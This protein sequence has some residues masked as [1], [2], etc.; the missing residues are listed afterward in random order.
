MSSTTIETCRACGA[1]PLSP[2]LSLGK[3]PLANSL[4]KPEDLGKPEATF[5]L[6]LVLCTACSLLQI[7]ETVA[8]EV[9]FAHY[10]YF[11]SFSDAMVRHAK[12]IAEKLVVE[13]KLGANSLACEIASNDGYLL[14]HYKA[15]GVPV[16]GVEPAQN[17]AKVANE[18]GVDTLAEF[19]GHDVGAR[20]AREGRKAD[21]IHANNVLAHVADLNGVI[22]GFAAWLKD[23]GVAV[24][25]APYAKPFL[26]HIE[27]DTIYHE[28]LC[29][30]SLTAIDALVAR[31]GLVVADVEELTIHGGTLRYFLRKQSHAERGPRV[32]ALLA[33]EAAW[34]V[35]NPATYASFAARVDA[36]KVELNRVLRKLKS[37]GKTIAA[38]GAAAKGSTLL[39]AFGI[40]VSLIDFVADRSTYKQGHLM[41][42]VRIPIVAPEELEKRQP[43]YCVLLTW[44][45]KDEILQQQARYR[46]KGGKFIIPIPH[47]SIE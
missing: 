25:E 23:T 29:Y 3:T 39:N 31:H 15:N 5:P 28:H 35:K 27:F 4:R 6:D 19:F 11:S 20:L 34:G 30:F 37:D 36:L 43:D 38:Y 24:V 14:Q 12:A 46:E 33:K 47:V 32:Q 26:D 7:T 17:I 44:N 13:E 21:V 40:D 2:V 1:A 41:P 16:L 45:F 10:L 22:A 18:K 8:P 9:L 42:G